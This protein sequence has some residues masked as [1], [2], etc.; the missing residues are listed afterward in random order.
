MASLGYLG[1]YYYAM[2]IQTTVRRYSMGSSIWA[3]RLRG[4]EAS[5]TVPEESPD[6]KRI[7]ALVT[8]P[9]GILVYM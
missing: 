9:K 5:Y 4:D 3:K 8:E 7:L 6:R 2:Q 1:T